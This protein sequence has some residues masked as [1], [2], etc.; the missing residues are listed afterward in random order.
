MNPTP[1]AAQPAAQAGR[2]DR[3]RRREH[4]RPAQVKAT[5]TLTDSLAPAG[6]SYDV[7][8]RDLSDSGVSFILRDAMSV[9]Q[10]CRITLHNG[11]SVSYVAEVV[12]ARPLSTGKHEMAVQFR[13]PA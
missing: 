12:R 1:Q 10:T 4:R 11:K 3:E 7:L 9:G 2:F 8:T 13:R 5:V 6:T